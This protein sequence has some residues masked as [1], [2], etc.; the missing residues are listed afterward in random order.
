MPI[1]KPESTDEPKKGLYSGEMKNG[2]G[3]GIGR[4]IFGNGSSYQGLYKNGDRHGL[5]LSVFHNGNSY[6]GDF[7]N[8]KR[9]GHFHVILQMAIPM[10]E[11][12]KMTEGMGMVSQPTQQALS[13]LVNLG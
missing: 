9:D 5:G 13:I 7:K 10:L 11:A 1:P 12:L 4:E 2:K 8:G 3:E 6:F